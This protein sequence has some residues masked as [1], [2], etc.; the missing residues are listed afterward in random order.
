MHSHTFRM[1]PIHFD[2]RSPSWCLVPPTGNDEFFCWYPKIFQD[3]GTLIM[4]PRIN[5]HSETRSNW[6]T[7][8]SMDYSVLL[9]QRLTPTLLDLRHTVIDFVLCGIRTQVFNS[10]RL[11]WHVSFPKIQ[12]F[13]MNRTPF[14]L[15]ARII[16]DSPWNMDL[17]IISRHVS[18]LGI[19]LFHER[20]SSASFPLGIGRRRM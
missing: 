12:F 19:T 15:Q 8:H 9:D 20:R 5:V 17:N 14:L 4:A 3:S 11:N 16:Y 1:K 2:R 10:K 7:G 13:A 6:S 18:I